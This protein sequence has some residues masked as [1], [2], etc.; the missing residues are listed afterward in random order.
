MTID[1]QFTFPAVTIN[2]ELQINLD[3]FLTFDTLLERGYKMAKLISYWKDEGEQYV[4]ASIPNHL[5]LILVLLLQ[6]VGGRI[7]LFPRLR[8]K[9]VGSSLSS[10]Q[11][12]RK[13]V[14]E[15][16]EDPSARVVCPAVCDMER[17]LRGQIQRSSDQERL[18]L[19]FQ[20]GARV[21]HFHREVKRVHEGKSS[22]K[23]SLCFQNFE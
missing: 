11:Q 4:L 3:F 16:Q 5:V 19:C 2:N 21:E 12:I 14:R 13:F 10:P 18:R 23:S 22:S 9:R 1:F 17:R 8:H 6:D 7:G 15:N 20:H